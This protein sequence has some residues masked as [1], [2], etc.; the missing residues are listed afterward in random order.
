MRIVSEDLEDLIR[1]SLSPLHSDE[2]ELS[3]YP[4]REYGGRLYDTGP[5]SVPK[6]KAAL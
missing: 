1:K 3:I 5:L 4:R 6:A 2:F